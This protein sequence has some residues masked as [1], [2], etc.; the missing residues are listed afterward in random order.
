MHAPIRR[1]GAARAALLAL[2]LA[3]CQPAGG[4]LERFATG[5]FEQLE[6]G[7]ELSLPT[8][9]FVDGE[10]ASH[11]FEQWRGRVVVFNIWGEWCAPCV[12]EMP[13]LA[14]LQQRFPENEVAVIPIAFGETEDRESAEAKLAELVGDGLPFFYDD[15][16]RTSSDAETG[17]FPTTIIYRKDGTEAARL[18]LPADWASDQAVALVEAVRAG[19]G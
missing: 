18:M 19:E 6:L 10:G 13:T 4:G 14:A 1:A 16:F 11:T 7:R 8:S 9:S 2:F 3:A 12:E 17:A 15:D 5:E